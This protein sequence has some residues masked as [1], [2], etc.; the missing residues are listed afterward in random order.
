MHPADAAVDRPSVERHLDRG[1]QS[2]NR[3]RVRIVEFEAEHREVRIADRH[4]EVVV[5]VVERAEL[6]AH[7]I[8]H[9]TR[10]PARFEGQHLLGVERRR[11]P[12]AHRDV[13]AARPEP[14][15]DEC[16]EKIPV[17]HGPVER[18]LAREVRVRGGLDVFER[19]AVL[20]DRNVVG[21]AVPGIATADFELDR[22]GKLVGN[23]AENRFAIF[24]IRSL[25]HVFRRRISRRDADYE[26][27]R[28]ERVLVL[29][30]VQAEEPRERA[31]VGRDEIE[32]LGIDGLVHEIAEGRICGAGSVEIGPVGG[33]A[34]LIT[35]DRAELH[36]IGELVVDLQDRPGEF[37][38]SLEI[39]VRCDMERIVGRVHRIG[40]I[41]AH[42]EMV[43]VSL[44]QHRQGAIRLPEH[45]DP[46]ALRSQARVG[47]RVGTGNVPE[48]VTI[49][50]VESDARSER[51][52]ERKIDRALQAEIAV[53][54]GLARNVAVVTAIDYRVVRRDEYR[55]ARGVRP[56]ERAL[57]TTQHLDRRDVVVGF[58]GEV[59]REGRD[60]VAIGDDAR[61]RLRV[62]F[63][64]ADAAD[65]EVETLAEIV[66]G[67]RRHRELQLIDDVDT[68]L[69]KVVAGQHRRRDRRRLQRFGAAFC[70]DCD[71]SKDRRIVLCL[72]I[73]FGLGR[74]NGLRL[75]QAGPGKRQQRKTHPRGI[76][77]SSIFH[78]PSLQESI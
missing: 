33:S 57:R 63:G 5:A 18:N 23:L 35:G 16:V 74:L 62:V 45:A 44:E 10:L 55:A 59:T 51:F 2:R 20:D 36:A 39:G 26:L 30:P 17:V 47:A 8:V 14:R 48:A 64:L 73:G 76:S 3:C 40:R 22:V 58:L 34:V 11:C 69:R 32:F 6:R 13:E 61:G 54:A 71:G 60:A 65:I 53:V 75:H 38:Q 66:D 70:M 9:P 24:R 41:C 12:E 29:L 25:Q 68:H 1:F 21:S 49:L 50:A 43:V 27:T 28:R 72:R 31:R 42:V 4:L 15:S 7:M 77:R 67:G 78:D 19:K 46:R 56:A 37:V 52:A